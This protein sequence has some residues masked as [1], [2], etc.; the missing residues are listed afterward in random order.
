MTIMYLK[1]QNSTSSLATT[2]CWIRQL[3]C[4]ISCGARKLSKH[5]R[6]T[7]IKEKGLL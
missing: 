1:I 5:S 2:F 3:S 7:T 6:I 4:E